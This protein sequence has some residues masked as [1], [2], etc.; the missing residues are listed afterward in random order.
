[1]HLSIYICVCVFV[2]LFIIMYHYLSLFIV[3]YHYLSI[4]IIIFYHYLSIYWFIYISCISNLMNEWR[5]KPEPEPKE[6]LPQEAAQLCAKGAYSIC[7]YLGPRGFKMEQKRRC[8][9]LGRTRHSDPSHQWLLLHSL[10]WNQAKTQ[11]PLITYSTDGRCHP[12]AG[13]GVANGV[14][15][16]HFLPKLRQTACVAL[17]FST[18]IWK[19][20]GFPSRIPKTLGWTSLLHH[21]SRHVTPSVST[22]RGSF[23]IGFQWHPR[24]RLWLPWPPTCRLRQFSRS[25][26]ARYQASAPAPATSGAGSG[27]V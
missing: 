12:L 25:H 24:A 1:M 7:R 2:C 9:L 27:F 5:A 8:F 21:P 16:D 10:P 26:P 6:T 13:V 17:G 19:P 18:G 23:Q 11:H 3:I 4:F 20:Q 14:P 22:W 15:T